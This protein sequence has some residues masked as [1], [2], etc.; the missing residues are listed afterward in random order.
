MPQVLRLCNRIEA[1]VLASDDGSL[2]QAAAEAAEA[3]A[4]AAT[5]MQRSQQLTAA[6]SEARSPQE[7]LTIVAAD[8][9]QIFGT[10]RGAIGLVTADATHLEIVQMIGYQPAELAP[11][12]STPLDVSQPG[13]DV[14]RSGEPQFWESPD[15]LRMGYPQIGQTSLKSGAWPIVP[16]RGEGHIFGVLL[17]NFPAP[18]A[19]DPAARASL[20]TLARQCAAAIQRTQR[21][22][23]VAQARER[24]QRLQQ[25][26]AALG[27]VV[28]PEAVAAIVLRAGMAMISAD[29]AAT[30]AFD[31]VTKGFHLLSAHDD[32]GE[33]ALQFTQ[34][35]AATSGPL[36]DVRTTRE[37]VLIESPA[38]LA[39]RWPHLVTS[40]QRTGDLATVTVPLLFDTALVGALHLAFRRPHHFSAEEQEVLRA[41]S[42]QGAQALERTRLYT[43][44]RAARLK[45]ERIIARMTRLYAVISALAEAVTLDDVASVMVRQ[46]MAA[47]GASAG[48]VWQL[49]ADGTQLVALQ[50]AGYPPAHADQWR[51]IALDARV[52]MAEAARTARPILVARCGGSR[53]AAVCRCPG[54]AARP[55]NR[56]PAAARRW[57]RH[58]HHELQLLKAPQF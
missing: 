37:L 39:Q 15:V 44:E 19:F 21:Y 13:T 53:M 31:P 10:A 36:A 18:R 51:S 27:A 34:P 46:G 32:T 2:L 45:G 38:E 17:L 20:E 57:A 47:L 50:V 12:Q 49:S 6:L 55:G 35:L 48:S 23:I 22:A 52:P 3:Q 24:A 43:A 28:T 58:R 29:A 54:G 40:P 5:A 25:V 4:R 1:V 26:T 9:E 8:V 33:L 42:Q 56:A 14:V 16:L 41:L 7:V 30:F 11:W